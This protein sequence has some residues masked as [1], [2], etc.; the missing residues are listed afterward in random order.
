MDNPKLPLEL[1][2]EILKHL[3]AISLARSRQVCRSWRDLHS[4]RKYNLVW[5]NA[6][7]REIGEDV[8]IELRG[9]NAD[10]SASSDMDWEDLYKEWYRSRHIGEWPSVITELRGHTGPVWDVKFSGDRVISCG[11]DFTIRI[12]DTWTTQCIS[13]ILGHRNSICSIALRISLSKPSGATNSPHDLLVSGSRDC[14]VKVWDLNSLLLA[15][16]QPPTSSSC[17]VTFHGHTA[18]VNCVAVDSNLVASAS[19]DCSVRVWD[20]TMVWCNTFF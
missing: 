7:F 4:Q 6:C 16:Y 15:P 2:D 8:L 20:L 9:S 17:L 12:W 14:S 10:L 5:R 18:C 3:D 11:Q 1:I 13:T 19:D